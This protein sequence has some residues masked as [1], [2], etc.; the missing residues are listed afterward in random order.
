MFNPTIYHALAQAAADFNEQAAE[1]FESD[2]FRLIY[3]IIGTALTGLIGLGTAM[4]PFFMRRLEVEAEA[5]KA[6]RDRVQFLLEVNRRDR[7][8]LESIIRIDVQ[9]I[10]DIIE[11]ANAKISVL[12]D[13]TERQNQISADALEKVYARLLK[14]KDAEIQIREKRHDEGA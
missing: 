1:A 9:A 2:T 11:E 14:I 7:K 4:I 10:L 6:A 8:S 5:G 3:T 12:R 13:H